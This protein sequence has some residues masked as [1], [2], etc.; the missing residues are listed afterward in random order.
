MRS[1]WIAICTHMRVPFPVAPY[2]GAWITMVMLPDG[3]CPSW[4]RTLHGGE[5]SNKKYGIFT[6]FFE[7]RITQGAWIATS[8]PFTILGYFPVTLYT[9][10]GIATNMK[11][12][13]IA[14]DWF[15][16]CSKCVDSNRNSQPGHKEEGSIPLPEK[17]T[18]NG[19]MSHLPQVRG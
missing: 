5:D 2:E 4:S 7:S 1:A 13:T 16:P 18:A 10:A 15:A 9:G 14:R 3:R 12:R 17:R 8:R 19:F 11:F 6:T